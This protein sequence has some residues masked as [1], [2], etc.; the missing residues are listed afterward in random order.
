VP[1]SI[2]DFPAL[3][4]SGI[5]RTARS[6]LFYC[7]GS[8][9]GHVPSDAGTPESTDDRSGGKS[10]RVYL[11]ESD[12]LTCHGGTLYTRLGL[13]T[14]QFILV[15]SNQLSIRVTKD[16][17]WKE[18]KRIKRVVFHLLPSRSLLCP[19]LRNMSSAEPATSTVATPMTPSADAAVSAKTK[20]GRNVS[21]RP[22]KPTKT[23]TVRNQKP[24]SLKTKSWETRMAERTRLEAVK[25]LERYNPSLF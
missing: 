22:W 13:Y 17:D 6:E 25:K 8:I 19:S 1:E 21:G 3:S 12:D 10:E 4:L 9:D 18:K 23:A 5:L 15:R 7:F 2:A 24:A 14:L 20:L 11:R 16:S